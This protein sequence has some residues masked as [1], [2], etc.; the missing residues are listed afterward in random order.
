[1]KDITNTTGWVKWELWDGK[2]WVTK[3][4]THN[5]TNVAYKNLLAQQLATGVSG[6]MMNK[7]T[8]GTVNTSFTENSVALGATV[9]TTIE[10]TNTFTGKI[11]TGVGTILFA[12]S[13]TIQEV[14]LWF[15]TT[16]LAFTNISESVTSLNPLRLS[17]SVTHA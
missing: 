11:A 9:G 1:M 6:V 4:E 2:Q 3:G 14:G 8:A 13:Y 16:P 15:G 10:L 17:W 12:G 5:V 7:M